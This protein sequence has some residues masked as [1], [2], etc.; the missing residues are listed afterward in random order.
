MNIFYID[1]DAKVCAQQMVD[2]VV[3]MVLETSGCY[4]PHTAHLTV[5]SML[6]S[7]HQVA[8]LNV[9]RT[10]DDRETTLYSATHIN[11]PSAVWCRQSQQ[12]LQLALRSLLNL[13]QRIYLSLW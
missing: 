1:Q 9:G 13:A 4:R 5:K 2:H 3:K 8:R 12:Q 6:V 11:R 10:L 7:Q